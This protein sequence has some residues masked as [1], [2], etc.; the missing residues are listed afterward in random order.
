MYIID[1]K[2]DVVRAWQ[3]HKIEPK[4]FV[5]L[6][7]ELKIKAVPINVNSNISLVDCFQITVLKSDNKIVHIPA[8]YY[9]GFKAFK[10][11]SKLLILSNLTI[12]E[13]LTDDYRLS[14]KELNWI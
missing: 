12:S 6:E 5:V 3:G 14:T 4:W 11:N 13:S 9:N 7:G 8:G 2:L 1:V 10:P